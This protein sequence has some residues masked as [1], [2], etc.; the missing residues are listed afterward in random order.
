MVLNPIQVTEKSG[1]EPF[2]HDRSPIGTSLI[3]FWR[4]YASDITN[5]ALRGVLAEYIV[6]SAMGCADGVRTEWDT[7]DLKTPEGICIEV[8]SSAYIQTWFQNKHSRISF[9]IAPTKALDPATNVYTGQKK[10]HAHIYVFCVLAHRD[11][12]SL[13]P[14]DLDQWEFYVL[15]TSL[16][17]QTVGTQQTLALSR[18]TELGA[19]QTTYSEMKTVISNEYQT[20]V[21]SM[22]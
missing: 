13:N 2:I 10:R 3:D 1:E 11:K 12:E 15:P 6:A 17:N 19:V 21:N 8:K 9:G 14:L 18:L 22:D 20:S 16:L 7:I 4:W 5:N